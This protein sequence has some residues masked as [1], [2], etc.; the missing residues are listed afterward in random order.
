MGIA[1]DKKGS[2]EDLET[3]A[4]TPAPVETVVAEVDEDEVSTEIIPT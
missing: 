4:E 3:P 2:W 1:P